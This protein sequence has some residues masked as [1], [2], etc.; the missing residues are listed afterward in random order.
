MVDDGVATGAT[1]KAALRAIRRRRPKELV[2]A[3]P[4]APVDLIGELRRQ[5]DALFCLETP[6]PFR[7]LAPFR[8]F[9][10]DDGQGGQSDPCAVSGAKRAEARLSPQAQ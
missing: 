1:V 6:Q 9:P 10:P 4:V 8:R 2:L 7:L 3:I 5:V